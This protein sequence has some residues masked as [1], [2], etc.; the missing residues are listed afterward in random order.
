MWFIGVCILGCTEC[1]PTE[2]LNKRALEIVT[3]VREKLTGRDFIPEK[4]LTV[5]RQVHLLTKEATAH[6]NLS[7]CYI[8]WC[9][10]VHII[11]YQN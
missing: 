11:W 10:W 4:E 7:Q 5:P 1:E 3:R 8:G 9:V 6:E 2:A